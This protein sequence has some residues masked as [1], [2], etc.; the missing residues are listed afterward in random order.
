MLEAK[1]Q[2]NL[3]INRLLKIINN[4]IKDYIKKDEENNSFNIDEFL[5]I[6]INEDDKDVFARIQ[7]NLKT[8]ERKYK[9]NK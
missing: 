9:T 5:D 7:K 8:L 1:D 3:N 6:N 4:I 2:Q